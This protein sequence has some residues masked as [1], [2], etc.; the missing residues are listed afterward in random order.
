MVQKFLLT[1][2]INDKVLDKAQAKANKLVETL[3]EAERL[4]AKLDKREDEPPI[5]E[6]AKQFK[7]PPEITCQ[8][9]PQLFFM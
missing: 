3:R 7:T 8:C 6:W 4:M 1:P 2:E 5:Y 9:Q